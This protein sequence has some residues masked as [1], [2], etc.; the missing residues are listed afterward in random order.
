MGADL[1]LADAGDGCKYTMLSSIACLADAGFPVAKYGQP[2][3]KLEAAVLLLE[4]YNACSAVFGR[5]LGRL[6][7][8]LYLLLSLANIASLYESSDLLQQKCIWM[9]IRAAVN[10]A[11]DLMDFGLNL[12]PNC[13]LGS[14]SIGS[15]AWNQLLLHISLL[16][17][18]YIRQVFSLLVVESAV[19]LVLLPDACIAGLRVWSVAAHGDP[20]DGWLLVPLVEYWGCCVAVTSIVWL[21]DTASRHQHQCASRELA[22]HMPTHSSPGRYSKIRGI[23]GE[24]HIE[25]TELSININTQRQTRKSKT[26]SIQQH[27]GSSY[28]D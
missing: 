19:L 21:L 25:A 7:L 14:A 12:R 16:M 23:L 20:Q 6:W 24:E 10:A 5:Q 2:S 3:G 15:L 26:R 17:Q 18:N 13:R 1:S 4:E 27:F 11:A 28:A 8:A 9:V 22:S